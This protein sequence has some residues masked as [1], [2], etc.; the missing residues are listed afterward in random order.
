MI[1]LVFMLLASVS[2][3]VVAA[4]AAHAEVGYGSAVD[5]VEVK[6][7]RRSEAEAVL[8][9]VATR[10]GATLE[11]GRLQSDL[12]AIFQLGLYTDVQADLS[13]VEGRNVLTFLLTEKASIRAV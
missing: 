4:P 3:V 10:A 13:E 6:G 1:R 11:R 8:S 9:V 12:R 2:L 5:R 7:N